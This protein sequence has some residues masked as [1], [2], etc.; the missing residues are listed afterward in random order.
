MYYSLRVAVSSVLLLLASPLLR[1]Q[2]GPECMLLQPQRVFDGSEMLVEHDVLVVGDTISAVGRRGT[3]STP[4]NCSVREYPASTVLPGLIEGHAHLL[5]HPYDE[6]PWNDQVLRESYAE[7]AIRG[8]LHA[9]RT[10]QAGFTTVRDLGSEGAGYT[11]V[12]LKQAIEK[13]V[14]PGPRLLVAGKAIVATGSYGPKGFTEQVT[15]PLGAEQADGID[16][17]TRV[18]RDQIGQGADLIKVYADYRWGPDGTAQP[19]FT[20]TELE[21]IV[22]VASSSGRPVVAHAATAEGMRRA[23]LGGVATIEHGDDGTPEVFALMA[24]RGVALCPTLAAGDAISQY[25][26]WKKGVDPEPAR[27]TAKRASFAQALAAGVTIVAGGDVGVFTH[28]DNVRELEMMVDYG[29][30]TMDVLRAATSGN[31]DVF[32]LADRVGRLRPG[33]LADLIIVTGNPEAD[34]S[35][36]RRVEL[37]LLGGEQVFTEG[38]QD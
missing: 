5:L 31:A 36:L 24:E 14:V 20:Q 32:G 22:E 8:A 34:I 16:E 18:V 33:L 37:V 13:G 15:V 17:L 7:R 27:I 29:M 25:R 9:G 6:T 4:A 23:T 28:G 12:G 1:A 3:L 10:L 38:Q 11:D 2:E 26:G 30:P 19:T 35:A 21:L